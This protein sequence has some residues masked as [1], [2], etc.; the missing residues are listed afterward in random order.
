MEKESADLAVVGAGVVGLAHAYH[1]AKKGL[2]VVLFEREQF[3]IGAS[4]RNF[5]MLWPIGQTPGEGLEMALCSRAHWLDISAQAGLWV[6]P[7]GSLHVVYHQDEWDVLNEFV[8][9]YAGSAY[10]VQLLSA[11]EVLKKSPVVNPKGLLGGLWSNTECV[12]NSRESV[13]KIPLWLEEKFGITLCFGETVKEIALP[14]IATTTQEWE[15]QK[16][17]ICSGAEFETLY[18]AVFKENEMK[19]CKLQMLKAVSSKKEFS[20]GPSLCAGL[21]LRHYSAFAKCPSLKKVDARYDG[22][23]MDLKNHGI[24]VLLSQNNFGELII[25]D[26]HHYGL[27]MEPFDREDLNENHHQLS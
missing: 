3:A 18:P 12:I 7:S 19:K 21:T 11:E 4:V 16:A 2:K 5:G 6:N 9:L 25:G 26:T 13:R 27:T 14:K 15:V 23:S 8:T 22:E 10:Q 24:H 17:V 20:I 1:A